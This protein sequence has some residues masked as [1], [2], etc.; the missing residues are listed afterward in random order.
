MTMTNEQE[1][2]I[3]LD[4]LKEF[5]DDHDSGQCRCDLTDGGYGLCLAG[6]W[7]EGCIDN[8]EVIRALG[9]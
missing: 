6:Q 3:V 8:A 7:S 5:L 1:T 4:L 2:Q 9:A